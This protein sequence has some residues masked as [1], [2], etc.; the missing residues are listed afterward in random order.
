MKRTLTDEQFMAWHKTAKALF[1]VE[2]GP[3]C[4]NQRT[5]YTMLDQ[6][7][8]EEMFYEH[9]WMKDNTFILYIASF[10]IPEDH[11]YMKIAKKYGALWQEHP[12]AEDGMGC[13]YWRTVG[14]E[15]DIMKTIFFYLWEIKEMKKKKKERGDR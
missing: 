7:V 2:F 4:R 8:H 3:M 11:E 12:Y 1:T 14:I 10:N 15:E 13:P 6:E 9:N 5:G